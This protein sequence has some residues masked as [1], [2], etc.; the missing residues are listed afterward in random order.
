MSTYVDAVRVRFVMIG[1]GICSIELC[2]DRL[3]VGERSIDSRAR[4]GEPLPSACADKRDRLPGELP[5]VDGPPSGVAGKRD[6]RLADG[7]EDDADGG[8]PSGFDAMMMRN[9]C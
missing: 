7:D 4:S 5:P 2:G 8:P 6:D 9:L 1:L 3:G